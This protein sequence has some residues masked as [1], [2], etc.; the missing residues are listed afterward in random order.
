MNMIL[1]LSAVALITG[2]IVP[3]FAAKRRKGRSR[4]RNFVAIPFASSITVGALNDNVAVLGPL[5]TA[6]FGEDIYILSVDATWSM[7]GHTAA[8][9]NFEIGFS[10]GDLTVGEVEEALSAEV[11]NPDD[12]IAK[13]RARRPVR[14]AGRFLGVVA[15]EVLFDGA[16]RR[17]K[18]KF[19]IGDG[20]VLNAWAVNRSGAQFTTGTIVDISGTIY[21]RWQR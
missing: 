6:N 8:E 3:V 5:T 11:I 21:G 9:G 14:R 10:H 19:S 15:T 7:R 17:T 20:F 12:I 1:V 16:L 13:E 18:C 4:R 2:C